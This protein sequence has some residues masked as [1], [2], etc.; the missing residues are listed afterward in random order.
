MELSSKVDRAARKGLAHPNR[1]ARLKSRLNA[2]LKAKA[3]PAV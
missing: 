3:A 1:A 2:R